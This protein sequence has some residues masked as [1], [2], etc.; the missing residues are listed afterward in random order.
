MRLRI[1]ILLVLGSLIFTSQTANAFSFPFDLIKILKNGTDSVNISQTKFNTFPFGGKITSSKTAC[2]VKFW[3]WQTV[4]GYPVPCPNCGSI[5]IAGTV[6]D[7]GPPGIKASKVYTPPG[8]TKIYPNN[9]QNKV[10]VYTLGIAFSS[11]YTKQ[12][13]EKV[14]DKV[15]SSLSS[16]RVPIPNGW[17]DHFHLVCPSDGSIILK[18]GTS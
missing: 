7:V 10:G 14:I 12:I 16:I 18:I 11:T 9:H 4:Y 17:L 8:I 5:P 1:V 13:M 6:I 2:S 15:N 3:I